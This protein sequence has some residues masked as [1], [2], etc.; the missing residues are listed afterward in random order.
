MTLIDLGCQVMIA[1]FGKKMDIPLMNMW[2]KEVASC[3]ILERLTYTIR[4][5]AGEFEQVWHPL[6]DF[7]YVGVLT[8]MRCAECT[9]Y[10]FYY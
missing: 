2:V 6:L 8:F 4:G 9:F 5:K 3:V 1:L 10:L 7:L